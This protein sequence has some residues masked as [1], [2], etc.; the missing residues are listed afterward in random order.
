LRQRIE[1]LDDRMNRAAERLKSLESQS[2]DE[3]ASRLAEEKQAAEEALAAAD[4]QLNEAREAAETVRS[5]IEEQRGTIE[6]LRNE[7]EQARARRHERQGRLES[8]R[9]LNRSNDESKAVRQWLTD[10]DIDPEARVLEHIEV[11]DR[12]WTRAVE[13]VL[14]SWLK[15]VRVDRTDAVL[16]AELPESGLMLADQR[17]SDSVQGSLS[18]VVSGAGA[19]AAILGRVRRADDLAQA[20]IDAGFARSR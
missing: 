13:T 11:S 19:L 7:L 15:A 1:H 3:A 6:T 16:G 14:S 17:S 8:L 12:N 2:G 9:V 10:N 4:R 5:A 18:E 20:K